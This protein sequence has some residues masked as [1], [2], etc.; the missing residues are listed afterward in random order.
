MQEHAD[1]IVFSPE[2]L[3]MDLTPLLTT[4]FCAL[5]GAV[6][7]MVSEEEFKSFR[8]DLGARVLAGMMAAGLA[9]W[10]FGLYLWMR[11]NPVSIY[12]LELIV[13][14]GMALIPGGILYFLLKSDSAEATD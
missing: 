4:V 10:C 5:C 2:E 7:G 6:T 11:G 9:P 13:V 1:F 14:F 8:R 3:R 12:K